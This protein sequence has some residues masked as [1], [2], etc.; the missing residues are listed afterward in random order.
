MGEYML[1]GSAFTMQEMPLIESSTYTELQSISC[2]SNEECTA[3]GFYRSPASASYRPMTAQWFGTSGWT[4]S[5]LPIPPNATDGWLQGVSCPSVNYCAA[6]GFYR[7]TSDTWEPLVLRRNGPKYTTWEAQTPPAG[8]A[9]HTTE[10]AGI[11][12]TAKDD[13]TAVGNYAG[14]P[15]KPVAELWNGEKWKAQYPL[16]PTGRTENGAIE[17]T[18]VSCPHLGACTAAG[19]FQSSFEG[20]SALVE[21]Y[22]VK[23]PPS[24]TTTAASGITSNEANLNGTVNPNGLPTSYYFEYGP[25]ASYGNSTSA[26][27]IGEG[28]SPVFVSKRLSGL[29]VNA[30]YHYRVVATNT[31]G[32]VRKGEDQT[33]TTERAWSIQPL[34]SPK[35][36]SP[37][38]NGV[39]C[40]GE[41]FCTAVGDYKAGGVSRPFA[42]GS[43]GME[44]S[45]QPMPQE[46]E[47][48]TLASTA[49]LSSTECLA[50]GSI[51]T[52]EGVGVARAERW[53]GSKWELQALPLPPAKSSLLRSISCNSAGQCTAVGRYVAASTPRLLVLRWNGSTW[54]LL[55]V[56]EPE[57]AKTS[58]LNG[59]SCNRWVMLGVTFEEC[60]AVGVYT[61]ELGIP[62]P[63]SE[64]WTG[65][66]WEPRAILPKGLN[67][68]QLLGVSCAP[69]VTV[70]CI[71]VGYYTAAGVNYAFA[72][73]WTGSSWE[74]QTVNSP[75]ATKLAGVSCSST[76]L[77][78]A[79]GTSE[80]KQPATL[81]ARRWKE[82]Q[83]GGMSMPVPEGAS[84]LNGVF[85][86]SSGAC[87]AVGY[88]ETGPGISWPLAERY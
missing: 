20:L 68:T 43:K 83:W 64:R 38:L 42:E 39:G 78:I 82:S 61:R 85:C 19:F 49:C 75:E 54:Q 2:V 70:N 71:A 69:P 84:A 33:F 15:A 65:S 79:V 58:E 47:V 28:Q 62:E 32:F 76:T 44:W 34:P 35:G 73:K 56:P 25:T 6:A 59:V 8:E 37:R 40:A 5:A 13:C 4:A 14:N 67:G 60:M 30:T 81:T 10:L 21:T 74:T 87:T 53:N 27:E 50:V 77:C 46:A 22:S 3:V 9:G 31:A 41:A 23:S 63:F 88:A 52:P 1:N 57:G 86:T 29:A 72:Q 26:T 17:L 11:S 51:T 66:K 7:T 16:N 48:S 55:S 45:L 80:L 24:V 36:E 18:G 12:C